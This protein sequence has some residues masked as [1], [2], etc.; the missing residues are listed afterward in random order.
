MDSTHT[1]TARPRP[2]S[3][4]WSLAAL[5][6]V[7]TVGACGA[8]DPM[9]TP[10]EEVPGGAVGPDV[11]VAEDVKLL[12]VQLEYPLDGV[13]DVGEDA[14]LFLAISNTG[15][16]PVSLTDVSGPEFADATLSDG[17]LPLTVPANDNAY[18]GAEGEPVI[19]LEDLDRALHS[20]QSTPVTFT[21]GEVGSVTVDAMV[22]PEGQDPVPTYDFPDPAEDPSADN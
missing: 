14:R 1:A 18:I 15:S 3:A 21:F 8:E 12:Q 11:K 9:Q 17:T 5:A 13:L 16:E 10:Q 6:V 7:L 19:V 20:S 2:R 4:R 22:A